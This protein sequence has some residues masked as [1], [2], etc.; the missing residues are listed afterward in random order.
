MGLPY[1][2]NFWLPVIEF[3]KWNYEWYVK[4]KYSTFFYKQAEK[5]GRGVVTQSYFRLIANYYKVIHLEMFLNVGHKAK[6]EIFM[7]KPNSQ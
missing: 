7:S 3:I 1:T 2:I 5:T 6:L 4:D